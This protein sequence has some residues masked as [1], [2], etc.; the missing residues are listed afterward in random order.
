MLFGRFG[1]LLI[2]CLLFLVICLFKI[3]SNWTLSNLKGFAQ[4]WNLDA[5]VRKGFVRP[6]EQRYPSRRQKLES[7]RE[8]ASVY[9]RGWGEGAIWVGD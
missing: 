4:P 8:Q 1:E 3:T 2:F 9:Q 7:V 6:E 5:D